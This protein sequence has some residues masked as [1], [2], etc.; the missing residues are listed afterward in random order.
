MQ[1]KKLY[2]DLKEKNTRNRFVPIAS[3]I[4]VKT[5]LLTKSI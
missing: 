3:K 4:K 1:E 2:F 5:N